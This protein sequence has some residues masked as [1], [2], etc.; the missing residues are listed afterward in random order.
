MMTTFMRTL[1]EL[2]WIERIRFAVGALSLIPFCI[3]HVFAEL[4]FSDRSGV[5]V[6]T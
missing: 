5:V 6:E 2:E 3:N 1:L 4:G